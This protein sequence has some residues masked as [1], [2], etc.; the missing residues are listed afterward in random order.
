[1]LNILDYRSD[2]YTCIG[3]DGIIEFLIKSINIDKGLFV[4]FGAGDGIKHSNCRKLFDEGWS[5]VFIEADDDK[6][7]ALFDNYKNCESIHCYHGRVELAGNDMFDNIVKKYIENADIDFCSIDIDGLDLEVFETF[8]TLPKIVCIEGGQ[9][10][11]PFHP[12]VD[13]RTAKKNIQQSLCTM[14]DVFISK[15]Y[16]LLGSYQDSF[17]IRQEYANLFDVSK[18]LWQL[19]SDGLKAIPRRIPYI[20]S[21]VIVA[22]LKNRV[23]SYILKHSNFDKYSWEKRKEWAIKEKDKINIAIDSAINKFRNK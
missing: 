18:D 12:R 1:M 5:G 20:N 14:R 16:V 21:L 22:G 3:N 8:Q 4:E 23:F 11:E 15:G 13:A 7:K 19:Y 17:F 6:A 10:L 9:M 2:K